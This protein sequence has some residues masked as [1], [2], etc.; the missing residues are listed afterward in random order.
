MAVRGQGEID[1]LKLAFEL[2]MC[3]MIIVSVCSGS[4]WVVLRAFL[5]AMK[6][7]GSFLSSVFQYFICAKPE[8]L[9][10]HENSLHACS[11]F[12]ISYLVSS[13]SSIQV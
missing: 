3:T 2:Y 1:R 6:V 10:Q 9:F 12:E 5:G 4:I 11:N 13:S 8:H 7:C